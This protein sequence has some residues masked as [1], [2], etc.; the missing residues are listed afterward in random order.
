VLDSSRK[1][2]KQQKQWCCSNCPPHIDMYVLEQ[3]PGTRLPPPTLF[4]APLLET[5]CVKKE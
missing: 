3:L 5:T 4:P 2:R 1:G